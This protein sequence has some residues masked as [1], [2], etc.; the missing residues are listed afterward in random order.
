MAMPTDR[1][2]TL[3]RP[4]RP[5]AQM[6]VEYQFVLGRLWALNAAPSDS[7]SRAARLADLEDARRLLG[8]QARLCDAL[9]PEFAA[10]LCR[11]HAGEWASLMDRCAWCGRPGVF[12]DEPGE[13]FAW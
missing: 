12:H 5:I 11:G 8:D 6:I 13:D 4:S 2:H 10:A 1:D 3:A 7:G 9:G